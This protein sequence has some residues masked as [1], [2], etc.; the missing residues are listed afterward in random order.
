MGFIRKPD[1]FRVNP[2][3]LQGYKDLLALLRRTTQVLFA[4]DHKGRGFGIADVFQGR[5]PPVVLD[6]F[7]GGLVSDTS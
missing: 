6:I 7:P 4:V 5:L 3:F 2:Q 1:H